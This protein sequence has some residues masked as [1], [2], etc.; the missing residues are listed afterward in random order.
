[1]SRFRM[2][3][4]ALLFMVTTI[5]LFASG[6]QVAPS[7]PDPILPLL[8]AEAPMPA[9]VYANFGGRATD[10]PPPEDGPIEAQLMF[11]GAPQRRE[12][13]RQSPQRERLERRFL[14][15]L[16]AQPVW[17][18][19]LFRADM[20]RDHPGMHDRL[21]GWL[22]R[23]LAK[24]GDVI[25]DEENEYERQWIRKWLMMH[26]HHFREELVARASQV[27]EKDG[28]IPD[29][30][31]LTALI[32]LDWARARPLLERF[33]E[34]N[35]VALRAMALSLLYDRT[36]E[37]A[38]RRPLLA[39]ATDPQAPAGDRIRAG[40]SLLA[41]DWPGRDAWY[42]SLFRE[43]AALVDLLSAPLLAEPATWAPMVARLVRD[44]N[45]VIRSNALWA[46]IRLNTFAPRAETFAA[47]LP[48]L[49]D[50]SM[51][52]KEEGGQRVV[53]LQQLAQIR[54]PEAIPHL[55][56]ILGGPDAY[57]SE[58][59]ARA[60]AEYHAPEAGPLLRRLGTSARGMTLNAYAG[61]MTRCGALTDEDR[62]RHLEIYASKVSEIRESE[63]GDHW[64]VGGDFDSFDW[65]VGAQLSERKRAPLHLAA[66]LLDRVRA[67]EAT[68][69]RTANHLRLIVLSWATAPVHRYLVD[70]IADGTADRWAIRQALNYRG[71]LQAGFADDLRR[72]VKQS[73]RGA[74]IA[75]ALLDEA[76]AR[77]AILAGDDR[78][79]LLALVACAR[80]L[81]IALPVAAVGRLY[82]LGDDWL[83]LAADRYLVS[84][85]S[86]DAHRLL[87][88]Q[89]PGEALILGA[90]FNP[91]ERDPFVEWQAS[92]RDEVRRPN[93]PEE[94]FAMAMTQEGEWRE[95]V[96][97]RVR[98]G[99]A[100]LTAR[101]GAAAE[102]SRSLTDAELQRLR[103]LLDEIRFNEM[104][105]SI[106]VPES[107]S[108][109]DVSPPPRTRFLRVTQNGGRRVHTNLVHPQSPLETPHQ[110]LYELYRGLSRRP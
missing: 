28:G 71:E 18:P 94:I 43:E 37:P 80:L 40:K 69:P 92:L 64:L 62:I 61:A 7:L 8:D 83:R 50:P 78:E 15:L 91:K 104:P 16:D 93:G 67:M 103:T 109:V 23:P 70:R 5:V 9:S 73:G 84:E 99:R 90:P 30:Q 48:W 66:A 17:I 107:V 88:A 101:D 25:R 14:D 6:T 27:E 51:A 58:W 77:H 105:A 36:E 29:E 65:A 10:A 60:I 44:A 68:D 1:M 45:P 11:W 46:M 100:I 110:R 41:R 75:A 72:I 38:L 54:V 81:R 97:I 87:L 102:A 96:T 79:A 53:L 95:A 55:M 13:F 31:F 98:T 47:V 3:G 59:A 4:V 33:R 34:S 82:S 12:A 76:P 52:P 21:R 35:S 42:L 26:S 22:S 63:S 32:Q 57:L 86:P 24:T 89:H 85:D 106:H 39:I 49:S 2:R 56:A 20:L 19:I 74:G 108:G